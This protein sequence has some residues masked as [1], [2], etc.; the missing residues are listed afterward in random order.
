MQDMLPIVTQLVNQE[1]FTRVEGNLLAWSSRWS[2]QLE[3][4][5]CELVL[6]PLPSEIL[7]LIPPRNGGA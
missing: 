2:M 5:G 6:P 4:Y 1:S 7:R 3:P